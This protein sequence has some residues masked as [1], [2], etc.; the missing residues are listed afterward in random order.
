M[1]PGRTRR[2]MKTVSSWSL[3]V[4]APWRLHENQPQG[5]QD[6]KALFSEQSGTPKPATSTTTMYF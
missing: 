1:R 2:R 6:A 4:L 3:R 5:L